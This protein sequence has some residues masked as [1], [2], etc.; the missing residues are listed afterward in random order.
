MINLPKW[1]IANINPSFKDMESAT[2]IEMT[3]KIYGAMNQLIDEYNNFAIKL[4]KEFIEYRE[5]DLNDLSCFK[6]QII[7]LVND[8]TKMYD[9]KIQEHDTEIK[10]IMLYFNDKLKNE[11]I[12]IINDMKN[13]G[14]FNELIQQVF[15]EF[16]EEVE[17]LKNQYELL[18]IEFERDKAYIDTLQYIDFVEDVDYT[19]ELQSLIDLSFTTGK[20]LIFPF[21]KKL[22]ISK[23]INLLDY[24]NLDFNHCE[25]VIKNFDTNS[26]YLFMLNS[27]DGE[28]ALTDTA[29][30][31]ASIIKNLVIRNLN[32]D[33]NGESLKG[34]FIAGPCKFE[35]ITTYKLAQQVK[36]S[37]NYVDYAVV[38]G[39][40][41]N[42]VTYNALLAENN[43]LWQ[44][45]KRGQGDEVILKH[46]HAPTGQHVN[47]H[48]QNIIYL[49]SCYGGVIEGCT[50]GNIQLS[51]CNS[52]TIKNCHLEFGNIKLYYSNAT[53]LNNYIRKQC[54]T[55]TVYS[56]IVFDSTKGDG[57]I[58]WNPS[59]TLI[60]NLFIVDYNKINYINDTYDIDISN[61]VG[62]LVLINNKEQLY[63][64]AANATYNKYEVG[65]NVKTSDDV[66][67][68]NTATTNISN[69]RIIKDKVLTPFNHNHGNSGGYYNISTINGSSLYN[70]NITKQYYYRVIGVY[71][72][73]RKLG[74]GQS[75]SVQTVEYKSGNVSNVLLLHKDF[76]G[77]DATIKI[78]KGRASNNYT[79]VATVANGQAFI[80]NEHCLNGTQWKLRST[81]G[82]ADQYN[83][84]YGV[85]YL[86]NCSDAN[87]TNVIAY[88]K[89]LPTVGSWVVGDRVVNMSD[90]KTYFYNGTSW[91]EV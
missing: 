35:N 31:S 64:N 23:T 90:G 29:S 88:L 11:L 62:D 15:I 57:V 58:Q 28:S 7:D 6:K 77:L 56:A 1:Q 59:A 33:A 65:C 41:C 51:F 89:A 68:I 45:D 74:T 61:Y 67:Y 71:D 78:Y 85:E 26:N 22:Q 39:W 63:Y 5:N 53:L 30:S 36:W 79:K 16:A 49:A 87:Y 81:T 8:Y 12:T 66:L 76:K 52:V 38:D 37:T 50:N 83:Q 84:C 42:N 43:Q 70:G 18:K 3:A 72:D 24:C 40:A 13:T 46:I 48:N 55:D 27:S 34:F 73:V 25:I 4:E 91:T 14:E 2:A 80:D 54:N 9:F 20:K 69:Q 21:N 44:F 75:G 32:T 82:T 17:T 86:N 19:E 10:N 47:K 60:N